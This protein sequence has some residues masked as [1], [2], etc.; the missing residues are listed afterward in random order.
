MDEKSRGRK[1]SVFFAGTAVLESRLTYTVT[2]KYLFE[3]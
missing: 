2:R 3:G 1:Q